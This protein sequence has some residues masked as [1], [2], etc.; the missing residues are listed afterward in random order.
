MSVTDNLRREADLIESYE[1]VKSR[2]K[3]NTNKELLKQDLARIITDLLQQNCYFA[4][5]DQ[6]FDYLDEFYALDLSAKDSVIYEN[7]IWQVG[8]LI[9]ELINAKAPSK[10]FESLY[11][12]I[13]YQAS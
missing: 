11:A 8:K 9:K 10:V 7:V 12:R 1:Q 6:F 13:S 4:Q 2:L 3:T 5:V